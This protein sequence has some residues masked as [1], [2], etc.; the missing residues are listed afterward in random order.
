MSTI[1]SDAAEVAE[2][3]GFGLEI[4][5]FCT[6]LNMDTDFEKWDA[7]V[8]AEIS[9]VERVAFHAPF[10]ELCP[11]AIDPLIVEVAKKR[12]GQAYALMS[13]YGIDNMIVHSGFV[14]T[15]YYEDWFAANSVLFWREFLSDKP[16]GFCV[17]I[18]NVLEGSPDMLVD[19]ADAVGDDRF[20]L[21]LD[22][23]HAA[24]MGAGVPV[25]DWVERMAPF[26]GHVHLHNNYGNADLHNALGDGGV[27]VAAVIRAVTGAAPDVTF[28]VE[29]SRVRPSVDWLDANGFL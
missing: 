15:V 22:I 8:R 6:A 26:L 14:P 27:D 19:I 3:R 20:R 24:F 9:G 1:A 17:F 21:C 16:G 7:Q 25:L 5:E 10:N 4:T 12:Y 18:E 29:S 11:A 23:G 28:T 2:E 13:G